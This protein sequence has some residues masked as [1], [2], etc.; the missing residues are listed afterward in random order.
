[1]FSVIIQWEAKNAPRILTQI[2][3][4]LLDSR[5]Y[6]IKA[7]MCAGEEEKYKEEM[8]KKRKRLPV[9]STPNGFFLTLLFQR[10]PLGF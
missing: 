8:Q 7:T 4:D 3:E 1:M 10:S 2:A 5:L 9:M 6:V